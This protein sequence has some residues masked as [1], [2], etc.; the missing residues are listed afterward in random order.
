MHISH[1]FAPFCLKNSCTLF[2]FVCF[3]SP[4]FTARK[5]ILIIRA[6]FSFVKRYNGEFR[7]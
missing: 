5:Y 6:A 2:L 4:A 3:I 7:L 1:I